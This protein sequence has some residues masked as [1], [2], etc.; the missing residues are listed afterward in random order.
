MLHMGKNMPPEAAPV[1]SQ[2]S[3]KG[4]IKALTQHDKEKLEDSTSKSS[5]SSEITEDSL[6]LLIQSTLRQV[7]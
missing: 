1:S 3:V 4:Y 2:K 6:H 5:T 7:S